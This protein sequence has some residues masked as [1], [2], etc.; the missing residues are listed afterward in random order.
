[1]YLGSKKAA[2]MMLGRTMFCTPPPTVLELSVLACRF[3]SVYWPE[4]LSLP[5]CRWKLRSVT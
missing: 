4:L 3:D 2:S 1:M 5:S